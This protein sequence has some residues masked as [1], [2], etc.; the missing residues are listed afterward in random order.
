MQLF[1]LTGYFIIK[2]KYSLINDGA[3]EVTIIITLFEC[4]CTNSVSVFI[5]HD[6]FHK[7]KRSSTQYCLYLIFAW[8]QRFISTEAEANCGHYGGVHGARGSRKSSNFL[9]VH[10]N[11][12]IKTSLSNSVGSRCMFYLLC[13]H[14]GKALMIIYCITYV[15]A[16]RCLYTRGARFNFLNVILQKLKTKKVFL[17]LIE[18]IMVFLGLY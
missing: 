15:L 6:N 9:L 16:L 13:F 5:T 7:A 4:F 11:K 2:I 10:A 8:A 17:I 1:H 14:I 18:I 3:C 12:A